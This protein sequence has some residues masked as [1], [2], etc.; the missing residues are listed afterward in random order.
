MN[1]RWMNEWWKIDEWK[2]WIIGGWMKQ[3][4]E[5]ELCLDEKCELMEWKIVKT[6]KWKLCE[7]LIKGRW[8]KLWINNNK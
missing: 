4:H 7:W 8:M 3:I 2:P 6:C 5:W 1:G